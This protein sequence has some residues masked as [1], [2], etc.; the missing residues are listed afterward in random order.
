MPDKPIRL[1]S[2]SLSK[3]DPRIAVPAYDRSKLRPSIV[4]IGVGGFHRAHQ[5]VYLDRWLHLDPTQTWGIC[6]F[7]VLPGDKR[8]RDALRSQDYL[9]TVVERSAAGSQ[10][11]IIGSIIDFVYAP[12]DPAA[13]IERLASPETRIVSLTVTEGGYYVDD[14][15]GQFSSAHPDLQHD[16]RNPDKPITWMGYVLAALERRRERSIPAFTVMSCDNL[17]AN[18][19]VARRNLLAFAGLRDVQMQSWIA[20]HVSFPNSMVDRITPATTAGDTAALEAEF[21]VQDAWP[22]VTEPFLQWVIEDD[23]AL[24]RPAW[25]QVGAELVSEVLPYELMKMRLLNGSHLAMA[26]F[27]ALMGYALVHEIM[28]DPLIASFVRAFMEEVTP[29]VPVIPNVDLALYKETLIERFANPT[30]KDQTTRIC[31][32]GSAKLPKWL[33]PSILDLLDGNRSIELASLAVASWIRYLQLG[34][35]VNGQE[36][37][38]VDARSSELRDVATS[39]DDDPAAFLALPFLFDERLRQSSL[40]ILTVTAHF[41]QLREQ[42]PEQTLRQALQIGATT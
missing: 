24:G 6:G 2:S 40:F 11:R 13:A 17:Q 19:Q 5:A 8:L 7:G 20:T 35:D 41:H 14:G 29:V 36:Y 9:Y 33:L 27:G 31:S 38:I 22:V 32:E 18:G 12:E 15:T 16:L 42:G 39:L 21:H 34:H 37:E 26:Y 1:S 3:L 25:E 23:F 28:Q 30:I 4:H 10:P